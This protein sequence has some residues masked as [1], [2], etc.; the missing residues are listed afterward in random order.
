MSDR[1]PD[2]WE[3]FECWLRG[4]HLSRKVNWGNV[5][6]VRSQFERALELQP[7][8]ARSYIGLA[9]AQLKV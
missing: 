1:P 3:I 8:Y 5:S 7:D 2:N 4:V 6:A 9:L